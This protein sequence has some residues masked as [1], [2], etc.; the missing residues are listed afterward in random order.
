MSLWQPASARLPSE[1]ELP[2]SQHNF[3][4]FVPRGAE[5]DGEEDLDANLIRIMVHPTLFGVID[6]VIDAFQVH[7]P[8]A[9]FRIHQGDQTELNRLLEEFTMF[10]IVF[11][12]EIADAVQLVVRRQASESKVLAVGRLALWAP[13]ESARSMR[14]LELQPEG[15]ISLPLASSPY[16]R[17]AREVLQRHELE[18]V[19]AQRLRTTRLNEDQFELI[20]SRQTPAGIIEYHRLVL[21][22]VH[23]QRDVLKIPANHHGSITHSATLMKGSQG[24]ELANLFWDYVFSDRGQRI[25]RESGFD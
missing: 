5:R 19:Y 18:E 1:S 23:Q 14:V 21:A 2:M 24:R 10:D 15:R 12:G 11:S 22:G 6:Q 20:R 7:H 17:A 16:H 3:Q 9:R 4:G 13:L 8:E 25:F